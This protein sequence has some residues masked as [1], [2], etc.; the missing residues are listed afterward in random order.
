ITLQ[1][2]LGLA[3]DI[4]DM[5]RIRQYVYKIADSY[6]LSEQKQ[7]D[8]ALSLLCHPGQTLNAEMAMV[9]TIL[10]EA[11]RFSDP[12]PRS[13]AARV[14]LATYNGLVPLRVSKPDRFPQ[15]VVEA[16]CKFGF[17]RGSA[18]SPDYN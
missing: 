1:S 11:S 4:A 17:N 3:A 10:S 2:P 9:D 7:Q 5:A 8:L 14:L 15:G 18:A 16:I 6:G 12:G 13:Q